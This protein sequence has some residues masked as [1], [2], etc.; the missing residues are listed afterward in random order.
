MFGQLLNT[1]IISGFDCNEKGLLK[2][3]LSA[4]TMSPDVGVLLQDVNARWTEDGPMTLRNINIT[5]PKGKL[6]A[7]IGSVGSGK[8]KHNYIFFTMG[9]LDS[10]W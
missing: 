3:T 7:I 1:Y 5:M 2:K 4:M 9:G 10:G 8:V 6:C